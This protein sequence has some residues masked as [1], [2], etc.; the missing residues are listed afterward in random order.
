MV[1]MKKTLLMLTVLLLAAPAMAY[2]SI[3]VNDLG[4]GWAAIEYSA[5]TN[6]S[7]FGL[8]VTVSGANTITDIN[9]YHVGESNSTKGYGIFLGTIVID[10]NGDVT[11]YGNPIAPNSD[12][13]ATG[14][15]LDTNTVILELG[16]LYE[17]GNQ[18]PL[19]GKLCELKVSGCCTMSVEGEATRCGEVGMDAAGAV[20]EGGATSVV[21]DDTN[22]TDVQIDY[23]C[24]PCGT[25]ATCKGDM[26]GDCWIMLP[27]M[28]MLINLISAA[29]PPYQIPSTDPS[30][31]DC[32]D[33]NGDTWIML[34]DMYMLINQISAAGPPYQIPCP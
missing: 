8:K 12:P 1:D 9:N 33:M 22:C 23:S 20:L 28:Y 7:A 30:Y 34:P 15:G 27:D 25:C 14:T 16:A 13:G 3:D 11:T 19:S 17:D 29:G 24:S 18:P 32:G 31:N 5:D 4:N 2:V 10:G 6:V 21:I 26:N